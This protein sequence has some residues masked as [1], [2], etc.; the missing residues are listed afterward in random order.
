[1]SE[2]M[3]VEVASVRRRHEQAVLVVLVLAKLGTH[4]ALAARYGRHRDEYYFIDCGKHLAF[5][6]VDH[7]PM[8]PWLA[9]ASTKLFGDSLVMLRLP[10]ILAGAGAMW[11]TILLAR[12][13]GAN[14]FGQ[15]LAGM[16]LL[17]APA[18]LR[19]HGMLDIVAFE[20]LFW[21][22]AALLVADLIDGADKKRWL[23]VGLVAG[24]GLLNKH[25]MLLWGLG[26]G[27][28]MLATPLRAQ[29][30]SPWPWLGAVV[31]FLIISPN[32][33]WQAE[34]DWAT[35]EFIRTMGATVLADIPRPLFLAGQ[36]LYFGIFAL[37]IW[38]AGLVYFFTDAGK[39]YRLFGYLFV[40]V[41]VV[42]TVTGA[43]PYYSAPAYP[44]VFAAGGT[45]LGKWFESHRGLRAAFT[46]VLVGSGLLLASFTLPLFPLSTV[47]AA[48]GRALGW[49]VRP[50]DLTHD[51]HD[52]LGWAEQAEVVARV[53]EELTPEEQ[54]TAT[55]FTANYGQ[56]SA[57]NFHGGAYGL[58][59][60]TSGYM[61]HYLWGPDDSRTG[62]V[63]VVGGS[64][65][66][67]ATLCDAPEEAGRIRHEGA[68][69]SDVPISVCREHASLE[70]VWPKLKRYRHWRHE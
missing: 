23:L 33:I 13:F 52:E 20:P 70:A 36:V 5:G 44:L 67:L 16:A 27:V 46:V 66:Q 63:V 45:W 58:P 18:Y 25:T 47:D 43:K 11:L 29:L 24:L 12:R 40:T 7:A 37:P 17:F 50:T 68:M 21:T 56:A 31:A 55:I 54:K 41:L 3:P 35:V 39:H 9:G 14:V 22:A 8:V 15:A 10:S 42:L 61:T 1:M 26:L 64:T 38:L 19:M 2:S 4:L 6:Y 59:R 57:L 62:P 60:A 30:K 28:G 48:L 51:M 53:F 34:H 49:I 69:E 32:L 65:K